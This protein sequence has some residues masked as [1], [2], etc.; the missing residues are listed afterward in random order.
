MISVCERHRVLRPITDCQGVTVSLS[1]SFFFFFCKCKNVPQLLGITL[2]YFF[3]CLE[4][5]E[6]RRSSYQGRLGSNAL[7][8]SAVPRHQLKRLRPLGHDLSTPFPALFLSKGPPRGHRMYKRA[9]RWQG[10]S[11]HSD[12]IWVPGRPPAGLSPRLGYG[13]CAWERYSDCQL[14][15]LPLSRQIARQACPV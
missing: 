1:L 2:Q 9:G 4:H 13:H 11:T 10:C 6:C 5:M 15:G 14:L 8:L 7:G 3:S 12:L